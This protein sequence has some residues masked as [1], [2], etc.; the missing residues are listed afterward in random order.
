[1]AMQTDPNNTFLC[2]AI[3]WGGS[4]RLFDTRYRDGSVY[5]VDMRKT[6][7]HMK[8]FLNLAWSPDSRYIAINNRQDQVYMIDVRSSKSVRLGASKTLPTETNQMVFSADSESLWLA[9]GGSPGKIT[10]LPVPLLSNEGG[11]QLVAHQYTTIS[12]AADPRGRHIASAGSDCLVALWDQRH[13]V[14]TR[15]YSYATHPATAMSFNHTGSLLAWGTGTSGSSGG[16]EKN[17]TLVGTDTNFYWQEPTAAPVQQVR[18]HPKR[19]C[20]AYALAASGLPDERD[21]DRDRSRYSN[22]ENAV[23]HILNLPEI[24]TVN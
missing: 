8:D 14:C 19:N 23:V 11:T 13:L 17:L 22:R 15:T 3:S 21:R 1:M 10:I 5:D 7:P 9:S 12:L 20:L 2:A 4:F 6:S 18:W 16:G 24:A